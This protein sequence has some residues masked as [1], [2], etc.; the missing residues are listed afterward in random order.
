M[1]YLLFSGVPRGWQFYSCAK[2]CPAGMRLGSRLK[3]KIEPL[4]PKD[5]Q[6]VEVFWG[7]KKLGYLPARSEA[8]WRLLCASA[9]LSANIIEIS[10]DIPRIE[11]WLNL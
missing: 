9:P 11:V 6:A 4:N 2:K 10:A 1:S 7:S 8:I 3:L 5:R